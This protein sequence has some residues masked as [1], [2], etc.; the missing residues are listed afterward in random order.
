[1]ALDRTTLR[2][3]GAAFTEA[4]QLS[5]EAR[6][7]VDDRLTELAELL[8]IPDA[9]ATLGHGDESTLALLTGDLLLT[10]GRETATDDE[11]ALVVRCN[12]LRVT[13]VGY[14][15]E[16][17]TTLWE[18]QFRDRDPLRVEGRM[19]YPSA[20]GAAET[21][22]QREAFARAL[23]SS[24]GWRIAERAAAHGHEPHRDEATDPHP[25]APS[26]PTRRQV[27]DVWGNPLSKRRRRSR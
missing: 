20:P 12:R 14:R 11:G 17:Q 26:E 9:W 27:T 4:L 24:V 16:G 13:E 25:P 22:D 10:I 1:M 23:A 15:R 21:F 2:Q 7:G 3:L 6:R 18:F 19:N 8:P 5:A